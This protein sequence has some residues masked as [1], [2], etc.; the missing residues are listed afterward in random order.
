M[1]IGTAYRLRT[2]KTGLG[3]GGGITLQLKYLYTKS[4]L[5]IYRKIKNMI[6]VLNLETSN[7]KVNEAE[8][9]DNTKITAQMLSEQE[10]LAAQITDNRREI[11]ELTEAE[12]KELES[13]ANQYGRN[14]FEYHKCLMHFKHIGEEIP[15]DVPA[16]EYYDY[17]LKNFRN[18]KPKEEWTDVDYKADYSRWQRLHVASV[19]RQQLMKQEI[20]LIDRQ[21]RI[22]E[23]VR[24]GTD[25][26]VFSS[27]KFLEM[28][29]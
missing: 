29:S 1:E 13:L 6:G 24:N 16:I 14:S 19:L 21:K 23:R 5:N 7:I 4:I 26:D 9:V 20:P 27:Q 10:R 25:F 3:E 2:P 11:T 15:E 17:I 28:L 18:P 22:I 12:Q 8:K